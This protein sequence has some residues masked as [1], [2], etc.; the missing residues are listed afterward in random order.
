MIKAD[1]GE[2]QWYNAHLPERSEADVS[3]TLL[4]L[5]LKPRQEDVEPMRELED[6]GGKEETGSLSYTKPRFRLGKAYHPEVKVDR[7]RRGL[8]KDIS[9]RLDEGKLMSSGMRRR[10][11][12]AERDMQLARRELR[13]RQHEVDRRVAYLQRH[14]RQG[15]LQLDKLRDDRTSLYSDLKRENETKEMVKSRRGVFRTTSQ[16]KNAKQYALKGELSVTHG[17]NRDPNWHADPSDP[18][19]GREYRGTQRKKMVGPRNGH[20][21]HNALFGPRYPKVQEARSQRL[22][23]IELRGR[24]YNPITH[25]PIRVR[26]PTKPE[27]SRPFLRR[28]NNRAWSDDLPGIYP[29]SQ[30]AH[31]AT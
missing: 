30:E 11:M 1:E 31:A 5:R 12:Q 24:T 10:A 3:K 29:H 20:D 22:R 15:V 18:L 21:S 6:Y 25:T 13:K 28:H 7:S 27:V 14:H 26:P 19:Q 17:G 23:D 8:P 4:E 16:V 2:S 9:K